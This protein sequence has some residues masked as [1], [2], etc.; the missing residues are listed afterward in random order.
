[1]THP[2]LDR[3]IGRWAVCG[4]GLVGRVDQIR[5]DARGPMFVGV[6]LVTGAGWQTRSPQ[7]LSE[8][9]SKLFTSMTD[10]R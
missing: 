10:V 3:L 5:Y 9:Y 4:A 6:R 1:V 7:L 2:D 8:G